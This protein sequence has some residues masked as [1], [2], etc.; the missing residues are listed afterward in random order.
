MDT[1]PLHP[2]ANVMLSVL[3][4]TT[5]FGLWKGMAWQLA[6]FS[7]IVVSCLVAVRFGSALA[8]H[9]SDR[10]PWNRFLGMLILYLVTSAGIWLLFR[11]VAGVIDRVHLKEF[12][13]QVGA[14]LG[15]AKGILLCLVIT[16]FAVTLWQDLKQSVLRSHS[17]YY[18][19]ALIREAA[20]IMPEEVQGVLSRLHRELTPTS[21][22]ASTTD[23]AV[24]ET[25]DRTVGSDSDSLRT[26]LEGRLREEVGQRVDQA[27]DRALERL[28]DFS[29]NHPSAGFPNVPAIPPVLP[30]SWP[31]GAGQG[32]CQPAW[33][34][35]LTTARDA[36]ASFLEPIQTA[37][38]AQ[39]EMR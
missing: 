36:A 9:L 2:Y 30:E 10:E 13:R 14:L 16:F 18:I 19:A 22:P 1:M 17:G 32:S 8:P 27:M 29:P 4:L 7:S 6:S 21:Q 28:P 11:L 25:L 38:S 39:G 12:D 5:L 24:E 37:P 20:P 33:D 31:G 23:T 26:Q 34:L 35:P 3:A 15:L